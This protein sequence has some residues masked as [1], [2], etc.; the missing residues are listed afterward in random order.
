MQCDRSA[1]YVVPWAF[2]DETLQLNYTHDDPLLV[3]PLATEVKRIQLQ[4]RT[5]LTLGTTWKVDPK[6]IPLVTPRA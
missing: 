5:T 1:K 2:A 4:R 3:L 6:H